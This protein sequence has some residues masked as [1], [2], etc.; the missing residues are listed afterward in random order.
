MW[1]ILQGETSST[2]TL[3]RTG[4]RLALTTAGAAGA[5]ALA[6]GAAFAA[7]STTVEPAGDYFSA[8][9]TSSATFTVGSVTV[10]CDTSE[11]TPTDPLGSDDANK[12]PEDN[13]NPDGP[14]VS[15]VNPPS[16]E[17]CT[18]NMPL[19]DAEVTT[20]GEWTIEAQGGS[21][22]TASLVLPQGGL[23]VQTSGLASCEAV[24]APNGSATAT[25]EWTNGDPATLSFSDVSTPVSV[26]GGTGCPTDSSEALFSADYE[27]NNESSPD[28]PI[29]I[30]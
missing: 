3:H 26:T 25:G 16:F 10:T 17:N 1:R 24:G 18:T 20:S 8:Q 28:T 21:P 4:A 2:R 15:A 27:V 6:S 19:V 22:S 9:L 12:V 11:T 29:T 30:Q 14:V 13:T 5:V 7:S 23:V